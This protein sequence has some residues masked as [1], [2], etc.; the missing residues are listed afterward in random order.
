M[1]LASLSLGACGQIDDIREVFDTRVLTEENDGNATGT[2]LEPVALRSRL[3]APTT[4][5]IDHWLEY[6]LDPGTG[7]EPESEG[8]DQGLGPLVHLEIRIEPETNVRDLEDLRSA[9]ETF[10][11]SGARVGELSGDEVLRA[12]RLLYDDDP[13][14][15]D[16]LQAATGRPVLLLA[17]RWPPDSGRGDEALDDL[18]GRPGVS[19]VTATARNRIH[20]SG[21][22]LEVD[23]VVSAPIRPFVHGQSGLA[24]AEGQ[25]LVI[26]QWDGGAIGS[27]LMPDVQLPAHLSFQQVR[28]DL[29]ASELDPPVPSSEE[30]RRLVQG[31]G[32][33][34]DRAGAQVRSC[35]SGPDA[36]RVE[37]RSDGGSW[38]T[39]VETPA[40]PDQ[41]IEQTPPGALATDAGWDRPTISPDG[42][43]VLASW[44][45]TCR[46]A[47][48]ALLDITTGALRWVGATSRDPWGGATAAV[49]WRA[50]GG[51][52]VTR[53]SGRCPTISA[54]SGL[55]VWDPLDGEL[56]LWQPAADAPGVLA[57]ATWSLELSR[58]IEG[59]DG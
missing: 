58:T 19:S 41:W 46:T 17:H 2:T 55:F 14:L 22:A 15:S 24:V 36:V 9:L 13:D 42:S 8:V 33:T 4:R 29:A 30:D 7:A 18:S 52:V 28:P 56:P 31:C 26:L 51:V 49:G 25:R 44:T 5:V 43:T 16:A 54:P 20:R 59:S 23:D 45:G 10:E 12:V 27:T 57:G 21:L 11:A 3:T 6:D 32:P 38:R 39:L 40:L 37:Y 47:G 1:A 50:D 53:S 34:S 35:R 48:A